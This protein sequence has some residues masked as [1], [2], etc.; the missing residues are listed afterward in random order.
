M[1]ESAEMFGPDPDL[2]SVNF[3]LIYSE[4]TRESAQ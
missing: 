4:Q 3:R 1:T 2:F